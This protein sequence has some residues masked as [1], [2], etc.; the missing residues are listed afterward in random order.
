MCL[1]LF[2]NRC[3]CILGQSTQAEAAAEID[4]LLLTVLVQIDCSPLIRQLICA[5][6]TPYCDQS[7][8]Q[9]AVLLPCQSLC[10]SSVT[11]CVS[12][13]QVIGYADLISPVM[14]CTILPVAGQE[15]CFTYTNTFEFTIVEVGYVRYWPL[16]WN[17]SQLNWNNLIEICLTLNFRQCSLTWSLR[18]IDMVILQTLISV[19]FKFPGFLPKILVFLPDFHLWLKKDLHQFLQVSFWYRLKI[20]W[21]YLKGNKTVISHNIQWWLTLFS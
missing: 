15:R 3:S 20:P 1:S 11:E 8:N 21:K 13:L 4:S 10:E 6:Y 9:P 7:G 17:N 12:L 14:D 18:F 2:V 16:N 19:W 5:L